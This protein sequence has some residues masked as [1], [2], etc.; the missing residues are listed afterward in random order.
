M[1]QT[2]LLNSIFSNLGPQYQPFSLMAHYIVMV[3]RTSLY[4]VT[5]YGLPKQ[6][7][8]VSKKILRVLE[9]EIGMN[10]KHINSRQLVKLNDLVGINR[11]N[12]LLSHIHDIVLVHKRAFETVEWKT[13]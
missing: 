8:L 6:V 4:L 7:E 2:A 13:L 12:L 10:G 3:M 11:V 1:L 5:D 9:H